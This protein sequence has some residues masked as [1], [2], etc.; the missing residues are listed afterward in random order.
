MKN[1]GYLDSRRQKKQR[2]NNVMLLA[3]MG[4]LVLVI[5]TLVF[6]VINNNRTSPSAGQITIPDST[7]GI[8]AEGTSLGDPD[9]PVLIEE[10]ADF[11][12]THCADFALNTLKTLEEQYIKTGQVYLVFHSVGDL[13]R[14]PATVQAAEAA[15]CAADQNAFWPYYDAVF[16]NQIAIFGGGSADLS[17][18]WKDLA[19]KMGLDG[20]QLADCLAQGKYSTQ[21]ADD[22]DLATQHGISGTPSFLI[23][24]QLLVGNQP[25]EKFQQAIESALE[26]ALQPAS[27]N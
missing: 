1:R 10:F 22:L 20:G 24:G 6:A 2:Q 19:E 11:G 4:G 25:Y 12:C 8:S 23:N 14:S 3:M 9:A 13:L 21:V 17:G 18:T 26:T 15:Y 16:A 27:S 7:S 5:G